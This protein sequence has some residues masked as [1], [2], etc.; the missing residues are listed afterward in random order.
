MTS[1][2]GPLTGAASEEY[3]Y[4]QALVILSQDL[5]PR[6][7]E[8]IREYIQN[9]SDALDAFTAISDQ[10][11]DY[12]E[13]IIKISIQ[14]RSLMIFDT[15]IGMDAEEVS[16]MRRVAYSEKKAGE[17]AGY[18]GIGRLA[19]I[20]VAEKLKISSTS[21]GDPNLHHFEFRAEEMRK[22]ISEKKKKGIQEP[23]SR[24]IEHHTSLWDDAIDPREHYTMVEVRGISESCPELLDA[25]A[26]R[27]YI[28]E[29]APVD[30]SPEF[31]WGTRIS[32]K[33][34]QNVSDY[35]PKTIYLATGG[36]RIRVYKPFTNDMSIAEPDFIEVSDPKNPNKL[37]AY[38]WFAT[39]GQEI[40]GK[41]RGSGRIFSVDGADKDSKQ[42]FAGLVYKLFGFSVGDRTLPLRTLWSKSS[43]RALWFTGEIHIVDKDIQ[44]TTDRSDF[45]D[46]PVRETFYR[47]GE[48]SISAKLNRLAQEIS[49]SR[50]TFD[51]SEAFR[52]D[53]KDLKDKLQ[54]GQIERA[55]LKTIEHELYAKIETLKNRQKNCRD[56]DIE[57]LS[58][59]VLKYGRSLQ[60]DL[61][62]AKSGRGSKGVPDLAAELRMPGKAEKVYRIIMNVL[63][64]HYDA[65][66]E[67]YYEI[68]GKI[69]QALKKHYS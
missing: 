10:I 44:P 21:Y 55:N 14:G 67:Q 52:K 54:N 13:P 1:D 69:E 64:V 59:E 2:D 8:V 48:E 20:A 23:A 4:A 3:V 9:A 50:K 26:L 12:T 16:K 56:K 61:E 62:D 40:L 28:G 6:K 30:F 68:A 58:A 17:E 29:V 7:L 27:E 35:S 66:P 41:I 49:N 33:I 39:K 60:K 31:S 19:G 25:K 32:Q 38:C 63:S 37:I 53:F 11:D 34:R 57:T 22:D 46:T 65:E 36:D 47:A 15:G 24:V 43:P 45:V 42:R 18:K 5:Y 51:D